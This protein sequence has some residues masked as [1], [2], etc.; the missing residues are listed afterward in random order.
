M[1]IPLVSAQ[2]VAFWIV[3]PIMVVCALGMVLSRKPV[4]S[5]LWLVGM[6]IGL[7]VMYGSLASPFLFVAQIIVYTGAIMMLFLFVVMLI[8]VDTHDSVIET[9]KGHR[10]AATLA[11]LGFG[12]LV[13]AVV[14]RAVTSPAVGL[15]A[16][17]NAA[18]GSVEAL[19]DLLF[20][21]YVV[22]FEATAALLTIAAV[23]A[24]VLAHGERLIP[25]LNQK[26]TAAKR[27]QAYAKDGDH[28][29]PLP[30]SGVYARYNAIH[31]PAL[32]PDGSVADLSV[33][34]TLSER[35]AYVDANELRA[36]S[37]ATF[38]AIAGLNNADTAG[39]LE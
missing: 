8:G 17:I 26:Q 19:A 13:I 12:A 18:G 14:G 4:H 23:G 31:A 29:G 21:R 10:V 2:E 37:D 35:G 6:M 38:R 30:N 32:L 39:E 22:V 1:L 36:P 20:S 34:K 28:L 9:I 3:A 16:P 11:A 5:A 15:D 7:A 33:S 27:M 25:K 24:M